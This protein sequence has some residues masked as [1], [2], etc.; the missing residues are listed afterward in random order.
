MADESVD[1]IQK[2]YKENTEMWE[3][4]EKYKN[5]IVL[6]TRP[7]SMHPDDWY[8]SIVMAH[9]PENNVHPFATWVCNIAFG[10]VRL[11]SG[12]YFNTKEEAFASFLK[13]RL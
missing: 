7:M 6:L 5:Y 1:I 9:L 4:N 8:L 12:E 13:R 2:W 10:E 3:R 11:S